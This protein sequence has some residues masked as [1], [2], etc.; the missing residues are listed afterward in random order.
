MDDLRGRMLTTVQYNILLVRWDCSLLCCNLT[1]K[2]VAARHMCTCSVVY[3]CVVGLQLA[4]LGQATPSKTERGCCYQLWRTGFA[5]CDNAYTDRPCGLVI[6]FYL[7][8]PP[9]D[10]DIGGEGFF[11]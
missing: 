3:V 7:Y 2:C 4:A 8:C 9:T 11:T 1:P 6:L 10:E 5:V